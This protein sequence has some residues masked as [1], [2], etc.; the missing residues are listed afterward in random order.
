MNYE[1]IMEYLFTSLSS[2]GGI[3]VLVFISK[4][5]FLKRINESISHEYKVEIEKLKSDLS[6]QNHQRNE[7]WITKKDACLKAMNL[8][9][10][11]LSNYEY[12]NEK[13]EK[14]K[15]QFET[16]ESARACYNELAC[17]C[18]SSDVLDQLKVIVAG[19]VS[20]DA[21]VDL[22]NAVRKEL[23]FTTGSI[24][25]DRKGPFLGRINCEPHE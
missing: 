3:A 5:W 19:A 7:L 22:R 6:A 20:P 16:V 2:A 17:T 13:K 23:G 18:E 10:A 1:K 12:Q 21:I 14:I 11:I 24:D 9:N 15:P 25:N 4:N 8:A